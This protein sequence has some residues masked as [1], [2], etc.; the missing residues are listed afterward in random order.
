MNVFWKQLIKFLHRKD[1]RA[2]LF[3]QYTLILKAARRCA[4]DLKHA[5]HDVWRVTRKP[6]GYHERSLMWLE[7]FEPTG[8]K[9]YRHKLHHKIDDLH[10]TIARLNALCEENGIDPI[11]PDA[12]PF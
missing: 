11:D 7:I 6:S 8:A 10:S 3:E 1:D 4:Y 12:I 5:D 2:E 9:D